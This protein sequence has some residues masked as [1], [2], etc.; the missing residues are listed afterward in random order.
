MTARAT[1]VAA[2]CLALAAGAGC[3]DD[4]AG[5]ADGPAGRS[6]TRSARD[7]SPRG[8][9]ERAQGAGG[10]DVD[11]NPRLRQRI[12]D[13][14]RRVADLERGRGATGAPSDDASPRA[15]APT[16]ADP[17]ETNRLRERVLAGAAT[18]EEARRFWRRLGDEADA[19]GVAP[20]DDVGD[21]PSTELPRN[22]REDVRLPLDEADARWD[23]VEPVAEGARGG[24]AAFDDP[25]ARID[26]G[27]CPIASS[28][29]FTL[30][31]Y[32]RTREPNFA[33]VLI[34]RDGDA[35]GVSLVMGRVPGHLSFEA[36]SWTTTRLTSKHRVDDGAWHEIEVTYDPK[37]RGAIL[38][39]D[40]VRQDAA[41][42]GPGG[43][44]TAMLRLGNN[45]GAD[46]PFKGDLDEV[47]VLRRT[48]HPEAFGR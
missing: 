44:P 19:A 36:W 48:A 8:D 13:L 35:V 15:D 23:R 7:G 39:I 9:L 1:V 12:A 32:L 6:A 38:S 14:E 16:Q 33:S 28:E 43:S 5:R 11:E 27:P 17:D 46:Q 30:H 41:V 18:P 25:L 37:T 47:Y 21:A 3:G 22:I 20:P 2:A 45:I 40:S 24:A 4:A 34:A 42:L 26:V 10:D 31:A 29:P